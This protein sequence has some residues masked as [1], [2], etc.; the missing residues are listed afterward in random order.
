[1]NDFIA[2]PV[3]PEVLFSTLLRLSQA[4]VGRPPRITRP[5]LHRQQGIGHR[6]MFHD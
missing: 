5:T 2:K 1:M 3:A 6:V 4:S